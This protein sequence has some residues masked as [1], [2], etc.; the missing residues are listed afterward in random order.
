MPVLSDADETG[1][2][3]VP[4]RKTTHCDPVKP[5][6]YQPVTVTR[7]GKKKIVSVQTARSKDSLRGQKG[8]GDVKA[9]GTVTK[10]S[11]HTMTARNQGRIAEDEHNRLD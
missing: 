4:S 9:V 10:A 6:T 11:A 5:A 7:Q 1:P 8:S 3:G 2:S